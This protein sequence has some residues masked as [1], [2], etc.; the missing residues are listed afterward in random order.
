MVALKIAG[1]L[2]APGLDTGPPRRPAAV[3]GRVDADNLTNRPQPRIG[4]GSFRKPDAEAVVE[5]VFQG[6]VVGLRRRHRRLEQHPP[7]DRQPPPVE[8]LHLVR[9]RDMSVQIRV[10]GSGIAGCKC[11][12]DQTG[13]LSASCAA[14]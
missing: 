2:P 8:G 10:A 1:Q 7:I 9:N 14:A 4:V 11:G 13:H 12:R 6:G 3:Q 5:V